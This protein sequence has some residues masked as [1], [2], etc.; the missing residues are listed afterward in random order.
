[1]TVSFA[2][3]VIRRTEMRIHLVSIITWLH[4]L[5]CWSEIQMHKDCNW[6]NW[7]AK[8]Q[9][10]KESSRTV[11]D[12]RQNYWNKFP[13]MIPVKMNIQAVTQIVYSRNL[14]HVDICYAD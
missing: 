8:N 5:F 10:G 1:M 3:Q 9:S 14:S 6:L 7:N 2:R 13:D 11:R 12:V 4:Y